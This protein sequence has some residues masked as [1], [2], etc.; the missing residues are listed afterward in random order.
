[1][2]M[3]LRTSDDWTA[4]QLSIDDGLG[5]QNWSPAADENSA[6]DAALS[7]K[8]WFDTNFAPETLTL[9]YNSDGAGGVNINLTFSASVD[10]TANAAAQT[11]TGHAAGPVS[12]DTFDTTWKGTLWPTAADFVVGRWHRYLDGTG[13]ASGVGCVRPGLPGTSAYLPT[14]EAIGDDVD[15]AR[16]YEELADIATPAT[17]WLYQSH[18]S[19]W[20]LVSVG[21]VERTR[22]AGAQWHLAVDVVGVES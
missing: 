4:A 17:A 13:A 3:A 22:V 14:V 16:L 2:G 9:I 11:L 15:M 1:M 21:N 5:A 8:D 20:R 7:L 19:T 6:Y 10:I 12:G 18:K